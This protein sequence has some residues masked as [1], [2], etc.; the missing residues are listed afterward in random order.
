MD[1]WMLAN[2]Y[3]V[4]SDHSRSWPPAAGEMYVRLRRA[5]REE[6]Q[7]MLCRKFITDPL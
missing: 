1:G 3:S 4:E 2:Q 7:P 5:N 6:V